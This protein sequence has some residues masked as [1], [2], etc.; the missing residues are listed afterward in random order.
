ML[1]IVYIIIV[2]KLRN[3]LGSFVKR[4]IVSSVIKVTGA[5]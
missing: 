4:M 1:V 5:E 2:A 3:N